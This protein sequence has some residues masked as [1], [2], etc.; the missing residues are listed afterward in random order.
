MLWFDFGNLIDQ[1]VETNVSQSQPRVHLLEELSAYSPCVLGVNWT[2]ANQQ[3][4]YLLCTKWH[5]KNMLE[6]TTS[7]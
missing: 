6:N 7:W 2:Q 1:S 5:W 3:L 4:F